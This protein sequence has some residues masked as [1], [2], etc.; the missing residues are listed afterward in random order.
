MNIVL[1][2]IK[3]ARY[4]PVTTKLWCHM[5]WYTW[6]LGV[7]VTEMESVANSAILESKE[8]QAAL[9]QLD[10]DFLTQ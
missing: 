1:G 9:L 5:F 2:L 10:T 3:L 8:T 4:F 7:Q 6:V